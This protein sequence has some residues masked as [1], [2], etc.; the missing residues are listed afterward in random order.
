MRRCVWMFVVLVCVMAV[1]AWAA[2][3]AGRVT[4]ATGG[5]I[6]GARVVLKD[7]ATGREVA[8]ETNAN[9]QYELSTPAAGT[10]R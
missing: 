6:S 9:G 5:G 4:D 7:Q 3:V 2:T 8:V 1:P 10:F